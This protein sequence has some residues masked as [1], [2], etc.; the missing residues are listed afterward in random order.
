MKKSMGKTEHKS[1]RSTYGIK[2]RK[3]FKF[4]DITVAVSLSIGG[5][6]SL[7]MFF[8]YDAWFM[9]LETLWGLGALFRPSERRDAG[10]WIILIGL[11]PVII[12]YPIVLII[13]KSLTRRKN[14]KKEEGR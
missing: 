5:L 13:D 11:P 8:N 4:F 3:L 14:T 10:L 2:N 9:N 6:V 7:F 1:K 12:T